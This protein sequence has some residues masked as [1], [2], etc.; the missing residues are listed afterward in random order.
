MLKMPPVLIT[1]IKNHRVK[2]SLIIFTF[3]C[4]FFISKLAF[5][6]YAIAYGYTPKYSKNFTHFDYVNPQ[7]PKGGRL[8]L[9]GSRTFDRLN[10]FLLKG[11]AA[12]GIEGL[13]IE[14]LMEQS[15]DEPYT[16]YGLLADDI[17]VAEN[18]LSVTYHIN[19][20]AKFSDGTSVT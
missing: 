8:N 15:L 5:S 12:D 18:G 1:I 6:D 16:F 17:E 3:G 9:N 14:T 19:P 11:V 13:I 4:L 10:P 7:A 20:K 2:N